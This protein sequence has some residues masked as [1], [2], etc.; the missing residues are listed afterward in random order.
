MKVRSM[1]GKPLDISYFLAAYGDKPALGNAKMNA[2][3]DIIGP[4]GKVIKTNAQMMSEYNRSNPKAVSKQVSL[5]NISSEVFNNPISPADA[6]KQ[7]KQKQPEVI[8]EHPVK[9]NRKLVD[10]DAGQI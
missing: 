10:P 5:K 7:A 1:R 3:G 8:L 9:K 6:V 2:R 4:G